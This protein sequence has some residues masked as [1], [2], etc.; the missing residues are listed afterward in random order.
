MTWNV[1]IPVVL[2]LDTELWGKMVSS[3]GGRST[4]VVHLKDGGGEEGAVRFT[5]TC[6]RG[7]QR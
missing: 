2:L 5:H 3:S 4:C 1:D 7:G 6:F